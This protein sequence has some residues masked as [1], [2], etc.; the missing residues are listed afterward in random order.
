[1]RLTP[2]SRHTGRAA[3]I[4]NLRGGLDDRLG[5]VKQIVH[6]ERVVAATLG[7]AGLADVQADYIY[8]ANLCAIEQ[9]FSSSSDLILR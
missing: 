3:L 8:L 7:A 5:P 2:V 4:G 1:M 6:C 9:A